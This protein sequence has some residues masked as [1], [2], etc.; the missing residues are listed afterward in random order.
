[1]AKLNRKKNEFI[2]ENSTDDESVDDSSHI[3]SSPIPVSDKYVFY[4][5]SAPDG[6][7]L[8]G[9]AD[10]YGEIPLHFVDKKVKLD[11]P[12]DHNDQMLLK[13]RMLAKHFELVSSP[14]ITHNLLNEL[15]KEAVQHREIEYW[16]FQH[17]DRVLYGESYSGEIALKIDSMTSEVVKCKNGVIRVTDLR[18]AKALAD[19]G[20]IEIVVQYK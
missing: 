18:Y 16:E 15:G 6:E 14:E 8:S 4:L 7:C 1:M 9:L 12:D 3:E 13:K 17:T 10:E 20:Y 5:A 19:A 2:T 11:V